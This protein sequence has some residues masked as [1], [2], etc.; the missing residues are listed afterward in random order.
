MFKKEY[1]GEVKSF[2]RTAYE[3]KGYERRIKKNDRTIKDIN[4]SINAQMVEGILDVKDQK[5]CE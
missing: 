2:G 3:I 4:E 5:Q 1:M